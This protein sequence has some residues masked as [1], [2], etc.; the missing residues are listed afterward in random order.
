MSE[1]TEEKSMQQTVALIET[2]LE[3]IK[4]NKA[5]KKE[6]LDLIEERRVIDAE[7]HKA[8][9]TEVKEVRSQSDELKATVVE[10]QSKI[11]QLRASGFAA[12]KGPDGSYRGMFANHMEAKAFGLMIMAAATANKTVCKNKHDMAS[13]ALNG[14]GIQ[15]IWL[16]D[17]GA[18]VMT[19]ASQAGG[20]ALVTVEMIPTMLTLFEQYGV[21]EGNAL[22]VPMG[23]GGTLQPKTDTLLSLYCPGEGGTITAQDPTI[24]VLTH[25]LKTL[26][27]LTAY[28][29]ELDEDSAIALG[30]LI[31]AIL[32]RSYGYGIDK[33]GFLGDGT[34]TYFGFK[35]IVGALRAVSAT[36]ASIKSL[37]VGSGNA[38]SELNDPLAQ[39][40]RFEQQGLDAKAG[41]E[42]AH[43]MD[44]DYVLAL[45]HGMPSAAQSAEKRPSVRR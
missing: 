42:E 19:G 23:T 33:L 8:A 40:E 25:T 36:I 5:T 29:M 27:A 35:G 3:D 11:N 18:K 31:A 9:Q 43:P 7:A 26:C 16:D 41:D 6:V 28:S 38:Y 17:S 22:T 45:M 24:A 15:S 34:S 2:G 10:L 1:K 44:E 20:S 21:F 30:E 37:T 13:K 32:V 12:I 39:R 4:K 14:M